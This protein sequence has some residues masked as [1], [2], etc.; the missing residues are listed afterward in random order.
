MLQRE[1][2]WIPD[3]PPVAFSDFAPGVAYQLPIRELIKSLH[4]LFGSAFLFY[5]LLFPICLAVSAIPAYTKKFALSVVVK[6]EGMEK[7]RGIPLPFSVF[8]VPFVT[9]QKERVFFSLRKRTLFPSSWKRS[10]FVPASRSRGTMVLF[11][12]AGKG[13]VALQVHQKC[14]LRIAPRSVGQSRIPGFAIAFVWYKLKGRPWTASLQ[15]CCRC[16][17]VLLWRSTLL[18]GCTNFVVSL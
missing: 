18:Q 17:R 8:L 16:C 1:M 15:H 5:I 6:G 2:E 10:R 12:S 3:N 9:L 13:Y 11:L 4:T 7:G 14:A